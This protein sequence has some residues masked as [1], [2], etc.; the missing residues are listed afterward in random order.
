MPG[1]AATRS[2]LR[3]W[4]VRGTCPSPGPSTVRYGGNT[5]CVEVRSAKGDVIVLDAGS[6]IRVLGHALEHE[7]EPRPVHL[8]LSHRHSD[9]VCGLQHFPPILARSRDVHVVCGNAGAQETEAFVAGL[10]CPPTFPLLPGVMDRL[11][12][13]DW[14][15]SAGVAVGSSSVV[16]RLPA[17]HPGQAAVIVVHDEDGPSVAYAPDNELSWTSTD[18]SVI[19]W[20]ASLARALHHVPILIHDATYT[21]DELAGH[22]G[23]GHSSAEEATRFAVQCG[24]GA[25][26][27]FHHHPDRHDDDVAQI[28]ERCQAL[29]HH[30]DSALSVHAAAEGLTLDL[31]V[32]VA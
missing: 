2:Q 21:D 15:E 24:A 14:S 8:F 30:L 11:T 12:F 18:P 22:V 25:L 32:H 9:H 20:R 4:G 29:A 10:L 27:L 23:W 26:M 31:R 6:G 1:V 13:A 16:R 3:C 7:A 17:R 28:A 19:A 5:P